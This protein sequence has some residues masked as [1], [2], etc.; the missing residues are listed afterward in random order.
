MKTKI[1]ITALLCALNINAK[2]DNHVPK[3]NVGLGYVSDFIY[4]GAALSD[5]ATQWSA[6]ANVNVSGVDIFTNILHNDAFDGDDATLYNL[7]VGKSF[8]DDLLTAY[9]GVENRRVDG[10]NTL[11]AIVSIEVSTVLSPTIVLAR[12]TEDS[13]YTYELNLSHGV[14]VGFGTLSITGGI[15]STEVTGNNRRDYSAVGA[16]FNKSFGDVDLQAG[17]HLVDS[18]D[19]D[20]DTISTVGLTY[21]F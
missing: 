15:G 6:G 14:D 13:L 12:N 7:G 16:E 3:A 20:K 4:R 10:D 8:A 17:V 2:A 19:L 1:V 18:D 21:K 9:V 11:D 5:E